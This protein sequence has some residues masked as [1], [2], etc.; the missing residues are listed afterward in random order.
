MSCENN[1]NLSS[2]DTDTYSIVM[3]SLIQMVGDQ[4]PCVTAEYSAGGDIMGGMASTGVSGAASIGCETLAVNYSNTTSE[5][6]NTVCSLQSTVNSQTL[7]SEMSQNVKIVL[8]AGGDITLGNVNVDQKIDWTLDSNVSISAQQITE[9]ATELTNAVLND[10][11]NQFELTSDGVSSQTDQTFINASNTVMT[12][13]NSNTSIVESTNE[14]IQQLNAI[15]NGELILNAGGNIKADNIT[16]SQEMI[17]NMVIGSAIEN[18]MSNIQTTIME[19]ETL[20]QLSN[21]ISMEVTGFNPQNL[22]S[23]WLTVAVVGGCVV[24]LALG[25]FAFFKSSQ[26][27]D[28]EE[29]N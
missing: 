18:I 29:I 20:N 13:I 16:F 7:S 17:V 4:D 3:N 27:I 2:V 21:D 19:N 12:S 15:Q 11:G 14:I 9:V 23:D 25:A 24:T 8:N 26:N 6:I 28:E 22:G 10:L 5:I 1:D